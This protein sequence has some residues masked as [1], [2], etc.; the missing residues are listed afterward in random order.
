[1]KKLISLVLTLSMLC[2]LC[3]PAVAAGDKQPTARTTEMFLGSAELYLA[4][5]SAQSPNK[6]CS[7]EEI[8]EKMLRSSAYIDRNLPVMKKLSA[9][10]IAAYGEA[11]T[12]DLPLLCDVLPYMGIYSLYHVEN[13]E[14]P[15][16]QLEAQSTAYSTAYG[17]APAYRQENS[18]KI[19]C[20][21]YAANFTFWA[22]PGQ[23]GYQDGS[24]ITDKT[25]VDDIATYVIADYARGPHLFPTV[26]SSA[27]AAINS[28][29]RRIATRVGT[30]LIQQDGN[31][32]SFFDFHFM[33]QLDDGGWAQKHG[34][35]PS[36][37]DGKINPSTSSNW[38]LPG[39]TQQY[40]SRTV[41]MAIP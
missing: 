38:T 30:F 11:A 12:Q 29:E 1:M 2:A 28:T 17:D 8:T 5:L 35:M 6:N 40:T 27:T 4:G 24:P 21:A 15:A 32:Y 16:A 41:Y 34:E 33:R 36:Q 13:I 31:L 25:T 26:I 19:N 20:Y 14:N 7:V 39:T 10:E 9:A 18:T 23:I 22:T 3:V 37:N